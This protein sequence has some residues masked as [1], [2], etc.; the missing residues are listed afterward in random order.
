MTLLGRDQILSGAPLAFQEVEV[1]EWGGA[2]RVR[3]MTAGERDA[4]DAL[5]LDGDQHLDLR[6]YRAKLVAATACDEEGKLLFGQG[7][8]EALT[9]LGT[10]A[11]DRL[12][13]AAATLNHLTS[14]D[15]EALG[16]VF[17]ARGG[18]SSSGSPSSSAA[19]SETSSGA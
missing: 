12:F 8:V 13:E 4:F 7:D 19:P 5:L 10:G 6:N 15:I 18:A 9:G 1:P 3:E 17:A 11:M 14:G 2:V 16:K